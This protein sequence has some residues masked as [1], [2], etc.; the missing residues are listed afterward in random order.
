VTTRIA[1]GRPDLARLIRAATRPR[2]QNVLVSRFIVLSF[3]KHDAI[4]CAD[5]R[6][7]S[8]AGDLAGQREL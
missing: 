3:A 4:A 5:A 8:L 1:G 6:P 2:D 7:P